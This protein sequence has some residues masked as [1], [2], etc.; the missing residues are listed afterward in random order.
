MEG[1]TGQYYSLTT[2]WRVAGQQQFWTQTSTGRYITPLGEL[3]VQGSDV[4]IKNDFR[5]PKS[6]AWARIE[7]V[8]ICEFY[9][10]GNNIPQRG[11]LAQQMGEIDPIYVFTADKAE[12][13]NGTE[14]DILN[15][16]DRAIMADMITVIQELQQKVTALE[17]QVANKVASE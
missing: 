7:V 3:A 4:R 2:V 9:Y 16:N 12:D 1:V 17:A 11:F 15:V 6:G 8:G 10:N 5:Q 13:E 14:F